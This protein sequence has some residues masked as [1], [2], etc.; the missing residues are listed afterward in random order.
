[1]QLLQN[2]YFVKY[3][4]SFRLARV[5]V[6]SPV[7]HTHIYSITEFLLCRAALSISFAVQCSSLPEYVHKFSWR[8]SWNITA[9]TRHFHCFQYD[10]NEEIWTVAWE[11]E[12]VRRARAWLYGWL[13]TVRHCLPPLIGQ[14]EVYFCKTRVGTAWFG[15][16]IFHHSTK[17]VFCAIL[18]SKY[19]CLTYNQPGIMTM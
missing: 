4:Y 6:R 11:Q 12:I 17:V 7:P 13:I 14:A 10:N 18:A 9:M 15:L 3:F 19:N 16:F 1:M 2:Q 8:T 5:R